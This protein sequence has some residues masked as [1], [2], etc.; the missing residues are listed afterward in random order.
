MGKTVLDISKDRLYILI[1][2]YM[3]EGLKI[4][5]IDPTE[6]MF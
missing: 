6:P 3:D 1:F 5:M 2:R 4:E